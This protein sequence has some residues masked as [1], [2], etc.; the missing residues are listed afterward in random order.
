MRHRVQR[1]NFQ[2]VNIGM[3]PSDLAEIFRTRLGTTQPRLQVDLFA[4]DLSRANLNL[5]DAALQ[6]ARVIAARAGPPTH[7]RDAVMALYNVK[8]AELSQLFPI[9]FLF[10]SA[11]RA[12]TAARLSLVYGDDL[13]WLPIRDAVTQGRNPRALHRLGTIAARRDVLD[14]VTHLLRGMGPGAAAIQTCYD[15]LEGGTL[16]HVERLIASHWSQIEQ[17]L[18]QNP[19]RAPLTASS[20]GNQ[21]RTVR[22]ARNDAYHHR[23]VQHRPRLVTITEQMLDMLD[24]S[25]EAR[26]KA[27]SFSALPPLAFTIPTAA[28]HR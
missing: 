13:W 1:V 6:E 15:L 17:A 7:A 24:I 22:N 28:R 9:F 20:F 21:F 3:N 10:E 2:E 18:R 16:A 23:L 19:A 11:F 5:M 12:F 14:T 26:L 8:L 4:A 25:L 27:L